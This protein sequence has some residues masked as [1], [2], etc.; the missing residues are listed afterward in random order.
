MKRIAFQ[1]SRCGV[2]RILPGDPKWEDAIVYAEHWFEITGWLSTRDRNCC[3]VEAVK[4]FLG[5]FDFIP[6]TASMFGSRA[7]FSKKSITESWPSD[8]EMRNV[9]KVGG[10]QLVWAPYD[11]AETRA[12]NSSAGRRAVVLEVIKAWWAPRI[13]VEIAATRL[14]FFVRSATIR[15]IAQEPDVRDAFDAALLLTS[16]RDAGRDTI[17]RDLIKHYLGISEDTITSPSN[18]AINL[19]GPR[20]EER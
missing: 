5:S 19:K 7:G 2:V 18:S 8:D 12:G 15:R 4:T 11:W 10:A 17:I 1:C 20:Y 13:L 3:F 16:E 9:L 14:P 6:A